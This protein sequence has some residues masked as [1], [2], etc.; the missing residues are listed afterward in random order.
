M[1]ALD[2]VKRGNGCILEV[3][4]ALD[5][6]RYYSGSVV[7][8]LYRSRRGRFDPFV[9]CYSGNL[10]GYQPAQWSASSHLARSVVGLVNTPTYVHEE[11]D[12]AV[13][14]ILYSVAKAKA[15]WAGGLCR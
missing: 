6:F 9:A 14:I 2:T 13:D 12:V 11:N 3:N 1:A 4:Y 15:I 8:G 7:T 10:P 5:N